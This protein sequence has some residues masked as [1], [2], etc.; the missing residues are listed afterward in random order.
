MGLSVGGQRPLLGARG[1]SSSGSSAGQRSERSSSSSPAQTG[2]QTD[3]DDDDDDGDDLMA[4]QAA[5]NDSAGA[6]LTGVSEPIHAVSCFTG[7]AHMQ[8]LGL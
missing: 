6:C 8:G 5:Y 3:S 2:G 7:C 1:R 4:M